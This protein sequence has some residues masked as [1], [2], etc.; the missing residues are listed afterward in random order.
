[1]NQKLE[2]YFEC[3]SLYN[4]IFQNNYFLQ[5]SVFKM[6]KILMICHVILKAKQIALVTVVIEN[7]KNVNIRSVMMLCVVFLLVFYVN[8]MI[9]LNINLAY[10]DIAVRVCDGLR[11]AFQDLAIE[12]INELRTARYSKNQCRQH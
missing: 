6:Q 5:F 1:M 2:I 3:Y 7:V 9:T 4:D 10:Q 11:C 8:V 12:K